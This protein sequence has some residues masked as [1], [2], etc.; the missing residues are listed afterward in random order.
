MHDNARNCERSRGA[1]PSVYT[2]GACFYAGTR[3]ECGAFAYYIPPNTVSTSPSS[4][5]VPFHIAAC[6]QRPGATNQHMQVTAAIQGIQALAQIVAH[7]RSNARTFDPGTA[8]NVGVGVGVDVDA[9]AL[10]CVTTSLYVVKVVNEW[11]ALWSKTGWMTKTKQPVKNAVILRELVQTVQENAVKV[12]A[13]LPT[14]LVDS[15]MTL[16]AADLVASAAKHY[17][18]SGCTFVRGP[19]RMDLCQDDAADE[20]TACHASGAAIITGAHR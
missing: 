1:R 14:D 13:S 19:V 9:A 18:R 8:A 6:S 17:A 2:E 10:E 16:R 12:R 20:A 5:A 7:A 4:S 15:A 11:A 3:R